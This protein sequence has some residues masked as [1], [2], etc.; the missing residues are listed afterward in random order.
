MCSATSTASPKRSPSYRRAIELDPNEEARNS[1]ACVLH[2]SM[3]FE[4]AE[5]EYRTCLDV[6]PDF[7]IARCN[8]ASVVM[9]LGRF[10]EGEMLCRDVI[11]RA[12]DLAL[13]H[14]FLG[15]AL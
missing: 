7:L 13:A 3:Q 12:P 10:D 5:R 9:D 8:L 14:S 6:A 11:S 1:L 2:K 15:V 4:E